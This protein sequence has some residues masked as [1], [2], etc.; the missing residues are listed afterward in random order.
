MGLEKQFKA[1]LETKFANFLSVPK[2][3]CLLI[4]LLFIVFLNIGMTNAEEEC[5]PFFTS[6]NLGMNYAWLRTFDGTETKNWLNVDYDPEKVE[7]DLEAIHSLGIRKLRAFLP[8]ESVMEYDGEKFFWNKEARKNLHDFFK[9]CASKQI[10]VIAIMRFGNH[11]GIHYS[12]DGKFRWDLIKTQE[13]IDKYVAAQTLYI[14]EYKKY[15]ILM[16]EIANEPYG[17]LTWNRAA[18]ESGVTKNHV[19]NYLKQ[20]YDNAKTLT[21]IYIGFSEIEEKQQEKYQFFSD[22]EKRARYVEDCTDVYSM[23]FYRPDATYIY[24]FSDL[25]DKPKWATEIGHLDYYDPCGS[26]HPIP[27]NYELYDQHENFYAVRDISQRLLNTGFSTV[28]LWSWGSNPGM[29]RHNPDGTYTLLRVARWIKDQIPSFNSE[30]LGMNLPWLNNH[31]GTESTN[32]LNTD[33]NPEK[34]EADLAGI[35]SLGVK[36]IRVFLMLESV[37]EYDGEKFFWNEKARE[38][39]HDFFRR[40]RSKD[41]SVITIMS[42]GH[43]DGIHES[44]DGK[45]RWDLITTQEGLDKYLAA[46]TLYIDEYKEYDI[47]MFEIANEPYGELT[48]SQAAIQLGITKDQVHNFLKQSYDNAKTLTDIY[49]GFSELEEQEQEKYQF[50]SNPENRKKYADDCTDV[51]SMHFYRPDASYIY[52]F[53]DLTDKPKWA[54]EIGHLNYYDPEM[55][56]H[57]MAGHKELYDEAQNYLAVMDISQKLLDTGFCAIY[58]WSWGSNPGM[59][60]HNPD[61]T[62]TL[63]KLARWVQE[64][65][66]N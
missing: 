48:W 56:V 52:D 64:Q 23:H 24:D 38:N 8:L 18:I 13:G 1:S 57:P 22:P 63:L 41:L 4:A 47:L 17:E 30:N 3:Q 26:Q 11:D 6:S 51:Y 44:L 28:Y 20:S 35:S 58:L 16:F 50:F 2:N 19:H 36:K 21:D 9:R 31:D 42:A 33:Y 10:S 59:V 61:G 45:F 54:T 25:T 62:H 66:N 40:C 15:D 55:I 46:Q 60:I 53:S 39:L 5:Q 27:G 32:W 49:V 7:V 12:L 29:V 14:N 34:I 37:M 65:L 43:H